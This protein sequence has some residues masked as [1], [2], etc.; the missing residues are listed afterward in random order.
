MSIHKK[1]V[2]IT[3]AAGFIGA[4]LAKKLIKNDFDVVGVDNLNEY[5]DVKLKNDRLFEIKKTSINFTSSKWSFYSNSIEDTNKLL[6]VFSKERPNIV[7]NLA[8][9]AG[10]RYSLSNPSS[11][12][13]TN[14]VGFGNILENCI[15]YDIENLIYAS[16]SSVYGGNKSLPYRETQSVDHPVSLYAA[17]K[18]ANEMMAHTYSHNYQLPATG[19]RFF[20]V[21]GPWG[22]PD[23]A[24]ILFAKAISR[25]EFINVNNYGNMKRDFTY[26]D[27][28]IEGI[29]RC[30]LKPAT[31][32]ENFDPLNPNPSSSYAPHR[33]FNI[34]S[35]NSVD[36]KYFIRIIE[37]N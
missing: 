21:Y 27:D 35:S 8:A 12:T 37:K 26:I 1:K 7:V 29:F 18:K 11:F 5:Y 30:C 6:E 20:T 31:S 22:R 28:I 13:K 19:L 15:K 17:T 34:G 4:A 24:P 25:G 23:M 32:D 3:G 9:Q 36:L 2:L 14:V 10:V 33:I 16:S